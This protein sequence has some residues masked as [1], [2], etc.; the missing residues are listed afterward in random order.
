MIIALMLLLG[1]THCRKKK[2]GFSVHMLICSTKKSL[3][4]H[5]D[6]MKEFCN[7]VELHVDAEASPFWKRDNSGKKDQRHPDLIIHNLTRRGSS[8]AIDISIANPFSQVGG[9]N[10]RPLAAALSR[11]TD[12]INKYAID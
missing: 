12:K 11:E 9:S 3:M 1:I 5:H 8:L 6:G 4:Q 7:A 2:D 10:P